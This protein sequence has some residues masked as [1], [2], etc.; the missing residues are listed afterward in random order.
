[1][2]IINIITQN[3]IITEDTEIIIKIESSITA[4]FHSQATQFQDARFR[5]LQSSSREFHYSQ[6]SKDQTSAQISQYLIDSSMNYEYLSNQSQSSSSASSSSSSSSSFSSSSS[7]SISRFYNQSEDD[8]FKQLTLLNK[9]YK[10]KNKFSDINNNFDYKVMIFYDKCRRARL[11]SHAYIQDV[12]IMLSDQTLI[13]YYSNQ[14]QLSHDFFDFCISIKNAFEES[15]WQRR[16]L[17]K[18]Q[19]ISISNVVAVNQSAS[20]SECLQKM[21]LE[22]NIIQREL[23][24]VFYDSTHLRKNI[25]RIC[26][27]HFALIND[28]N[29][30]SINVSDLINSLHINITN[31]EV[32]QKSIQSESYLQQN[33]SDQE[34][35]DQYFIDRQYRRENEFL[36]DR[37]DEYSNRRDEF[38]AEDRSNDEFRTRISRFSKK[39][40]VCDKHDCWSINH[41]EKKRDDSK[42]RF[43]D[44]HSEYK[45]RSEYDRRLKQ[46]I[47]DFEDI[48]DD[49]DDEN[50]TQ[51]FDEFSFISSVIDD[52]KL[53][54]FESSE[55][56]LTS[57]DELQNIEFVNS[58]LVIS[59]LANSF[60]NSFANK[61]FEHRLILKN[62]TNAFVNESFDFIYISIIESRYDDREFKSI[63]MNCDAARQSTTEIE[64]F[65]A[66]QRLNDSI[67]LDKSIV[68]SKIQFDIDSISIMS[69][70]KLN[71]SLKQLIFHIVEV[72]TPFL[73]CLVDLDRL[74]VYFNNLTNELM[75]KRI[76]ILQIDMKKPSSIIILQTDMKNVNLFSIIRRYEHAFLLWKILN[77]TLIVEFF[78]ENFFYLIE[79]E[80]RRLHRRFD[81]LSARRLH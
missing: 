55:L 65:T 39:C 22:M 15:E 18:W 7:Q 78:D 41:F 51:Y 50:A 72:N 37:R 68:E 3:K 79:I 1:M 60:I 73:L 30:A 19:I 9:I 43:F 48:I 35:D 38:R 42:K 17:I 36:Y 34:K 52:A 16:N 44:H 2:R 26:R 31:Y 53:I 14:L 33:S 6:I 27:N 77:Q 29:N 81:H 46:Y 32:V 71:T 54:E 58:S 75:Q 74:D 10:K 59:S 23:D 57:L 28:L 64:Q 63:L 69:T 8:F 21:C 76:I 61:A 45:T 25:I 49:S 13:H 66:L 62:I 20:L 5:L 47:A 12:S 24:F 80:L 56:F 11:S 67:Q 4:Y 40:F 70:I